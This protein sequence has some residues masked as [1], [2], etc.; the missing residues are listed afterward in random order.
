MKQEVQKN[1][2]RNGKSSS[3]GGESEV[4]VA[5]EIHNE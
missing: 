5:G 3:K 2:E 4:T 1:Q